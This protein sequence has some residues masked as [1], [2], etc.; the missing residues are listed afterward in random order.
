MAEVMSTHLADRSS[1]PPFGSP[2][3]GTHGNLRYRLLHFHLPLAIGSAVILFLWMTLPLFQAAGHRG[4]PQGSQATGHQSPAA[5]APPRA[6][7]QGSTH[8]GPAQ[9][10]GATPPE[11]HSDTQTADPTRTQ[12]RL[13]LARF[14]T[15]TGYIAL[16]L[17]GITLLVGPAN[18]LLRR[19]TPISTYLARDVGMWAAS[20][21]VVH[22]IAGFSVMARADAL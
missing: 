18:L 7:H 1:D 12:D 13:L 5:P 19:R 11:E 10:H 14:T 3:G 15:A 6:T 21:S 17:L 2:L 20:V 4:P 22:V 8:H 9:A 16:G